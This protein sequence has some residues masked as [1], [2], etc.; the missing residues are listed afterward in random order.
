MIP[1]AIV[2]HGRLGRS[3]RGGRT[4]LDGSL[5]FEKMGDEPRR[6][7]E[8]E[9]RTTHASRRGASS[10]LGVHALDPGEAGVAVEGLL[11]PSLE[12]E[13]ELLPHPR[14]GVAVPGRLFETLEK[15]GRGGERLVEGRRVLREGLEERQGA[16]LAM[17]RPILELEARSSVV[18]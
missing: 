10:T 14:I 5:Q 15:H 9:R 8:G 18:S 4:D 7:G 2:A 13:H 11:L 17:G 1:E 3:G 12:D 6:R 16:E